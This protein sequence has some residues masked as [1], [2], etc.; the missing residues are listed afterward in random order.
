MNKYDLCMKYADKWQED[1][2]W[3]VSNEFI[4]GTFA[5]RCF[6]G[7]TLEEAV[8]QL[9]DYFDCESAYEGRT[10]VK[11][12]LH[13]AGWYA[14]ADGIDEKQFEPEIHMS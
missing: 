1:G 12:C 14:D 9:V 4:C 8:Q 7:D 3:L 5:G 2:R 10:I 11:S 6:E 13:E